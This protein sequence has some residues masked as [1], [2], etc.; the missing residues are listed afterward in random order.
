MAVGTSPFPHPAMAQHH[1]APYQRVSQLL[2]AAAGLPHPLLSDG[3]LLLKAWGRH[4]RETVM[5]VKRRKWS[6]N[7]MTRWQLSGCFRK[8]QEAAAPSGCRSKRSC[9]D[10]RRGHERW[11][12]GTVF[13]SH[14][15]SW[16]S[17]K[18]RAGS[19][20]REWMG[21]HLCNAASGLRAL[22]VCSFASRLSSLSI[23]LRFDFSHAS[24]SWN[25]EVGE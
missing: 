18:V 9:R 23:T 2:L 25:T 20:W 8:D 17:V 10:S 12:A 14:L 13:L 15:C 7:G 11:N 3:C 16:N 5:L 19:K 4:G 1:T 24:V 21:T 22:G 6:K